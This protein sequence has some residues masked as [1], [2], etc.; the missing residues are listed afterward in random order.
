MRETLVKL[1]KQVGT[2]KR[3]CSLYSSHKIE[4]ETHRLLDCQRYS[5]MRDVFLSKIVEN[6]RMKI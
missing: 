6:Y 4:G 5:S 3:M 1:M 2:A